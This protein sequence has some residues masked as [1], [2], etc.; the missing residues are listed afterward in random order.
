MKQKIIIQEYKNQ[1]RDFCSAN[2]RN[3]SVDNGWLRGK[4]KVCHHLCECGQGRNEGIGRN[5]LNLRGLLLQSS[6][7]SAGW[8]EKHNVAKNESLSNL[9]TARTGR[10]WLLPDFVKRCKFMRHWL[11]VWSLLT[12]QFSPCKGPSSAWILDLWM[13]SRLIC[14]SSFARL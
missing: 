6:Q 12:S 8:E 11:S 5:L 1:V 10:R 3:V 7:L 2:Q 14:A 4:K 9:H 13:I